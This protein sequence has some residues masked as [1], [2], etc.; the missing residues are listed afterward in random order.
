VPTA[1]NGLTSQVVGK[2][3]YIIGGGANAG[4]MTFVSLRA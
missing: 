1:R 3:W 4:A 2:R